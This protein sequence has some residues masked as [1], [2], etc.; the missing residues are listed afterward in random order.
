MRR[1]RRV[2][3]AGLDGVASAE[4]HRRDH[5]IRVSTLNQTKRIICHLLAAGSAS[6]C[7]GGEPDGQSAPP[8]VIFVAQWP[9]FAWTQ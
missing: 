4:R 3:S 7:S 8:S 1:E 6:H 2:D 9:P 5:K